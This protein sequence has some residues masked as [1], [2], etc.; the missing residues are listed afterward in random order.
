MNTDLPVYNCSR[1][2]LLDADD[3]ALLLEHVI[4]AGPGTVWVPPGGGVERGESLEEAARRELWE[5][6]G[7]RVEAI[8]PLLW[9]RNS[10]WP[11]TE[12]QLTTVVEHYFLCRVDKHDVGEHLNIDEAERA[13][14]LNYKWWRLSEIEK[15]HSLFGPRRLGALLK[16]VLDGH[17][18]AEPIQIETGG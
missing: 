13:S 6:T 11:F 10:V 2:V 3:R 15:S 16:P 18:P 8:G 5:E 17:L 7:L 4:G 1:V 12:R 9:I 14:V